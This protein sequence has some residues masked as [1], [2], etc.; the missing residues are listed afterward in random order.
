MNN[1]NRYLDYV[2]ETYELIV[3]HLVERKLPV[4]DE[5]IRLY[6]NSIIRPYYFWAQEENQKPRVF[7]QDGRKIV[8]MSGKAG[9]LETPPR[10]PAKM[11]T[12][13]QLQLLRNLSKRLKK[14]VSDEYLQ[15]LSVDEAS[16][17]IDQWKGVK[18]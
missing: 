15:R 6:F 18:P 11:I 17:L 10:A 1:L 14:D 3:K 9:E 4:T 2:D 13:A 5:R 7:E 16:K 8:D 12:P